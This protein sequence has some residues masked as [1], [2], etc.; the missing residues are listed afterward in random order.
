MEG[1]A[2]FGLTL[3][4]KRTV[5]RYQRMR[6]ACRPD[7]CERAVRRWQSLRLTSFDRDPAAF[8]YWCVFLPV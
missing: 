8:R 5:G 1:G 2:F 7:G 3:L 4:D 6:Q